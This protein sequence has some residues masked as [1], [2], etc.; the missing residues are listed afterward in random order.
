[1]IYHKINDSIN[2][3]YSIIT[4]PKLE[5]SKR[6][7][8]V[9]PIIS[10]TGY[11]GFDRPI[12]IYGRNRY[13]ANGSVSSEDVMVQKVYYEKLDKTYEPPK[14][15]V[16]NILSNSTTINIPV[17]QQSTDSCS[18]VS[19]IN[20]IQSRI[21]YTLDYDQM[22]N[23]ISSSEPPPDNWISKGFGYTVP[24]PAFFVPGLSESQAIYYTKIIYKIWNLLS[25]GCFNAPK[26]SQELFCQSFANLPQYL[27]NGLGVCDSKCYKKFQL[28]PIRL[29]RPDR[30]PFN[31]TLCTRVNGGYALPV[32]LGNIQTRLLALRGYFRATY[33]GNN[34]WLPPDMGFPRPYN[35]YS[36]APLS[37]DDWN[38]LNSLVPG[39]FLMPIAKPL[40]HQVSLIGCSGPDS[41]GCYTFTIQNSWGNSFPNSSNPNI[42]ISTFTYESC[43]PDNFL[44]QLIRQQQDRPTIPSAGVPTGGRIIYYAP[45]DNCAFGVKECYM[46][47]STLDDKEC[48][49]CPLVCTPSGLVSTTYANNMCENRGFDG[50][51]RDYS[52]IESPGYKDCECICDEPRVFVPFSSP[53]EGEK[54]GYCVCPESKRIECDII[55]DLN[56]FELWVMDPNTCECY[57]LET[58]FSHIVP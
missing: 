40:A 24:Q 30:S 47:Y 56:P 57:Q 2:P 42:D 10:S 44:Q 38:L 19:I 46:P 58:A 21:N 23:C 34:D 54:E 53:G 1:M 49:L 41:N 13:A 35:W 12:K 20:L 18:L 27:G 36:Y 51:N 32:T 14:E 3:K 16:F 43:D 11:I 7:I 48:N 37:E 52:A 29:V 55:A 45:W 5:F 33:P 15:S 6:T 9:T 22:M 25:G 17:T 26:I 4:K 39:N 31:S 8:K 50:F 28:E